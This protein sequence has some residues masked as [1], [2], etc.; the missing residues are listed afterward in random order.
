MV[1]FGEV[2]KLAAVLLIRIRDTGSGAYSGIR[3]QFSKICTLIIIAAQPALVGTEDEETRPRSRPH[4]RTHA[5][6]VSIVFF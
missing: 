5:P 6:Q 4:T 2:G 3:V 1:N